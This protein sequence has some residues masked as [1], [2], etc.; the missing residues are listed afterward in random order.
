MQLDAHNYFTDRDWQKSLHMF[1]FML[2]SCLEYLLKNESNL[3]LNEYDIY[4]IKIHSILWKIMHLMFI[5]FW[6]ASPCYHKRIEAKK[7][8][9]V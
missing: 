1:W 7:R 2:S 9:I 8:I 6:I 5:I 3:K 4:V